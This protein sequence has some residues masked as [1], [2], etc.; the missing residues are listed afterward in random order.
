MSYTLTA[1]FIEIDNKFKFHRYFWEG[2]DAFYYGESSS[3][4]IHEK[5]TGYKLEKHQIDNFDFTNENAYY[6]VA[7]H[8][9]VI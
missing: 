8:Y 9:E 5:I 3:I 6:K 1:L 4:L 2:I 7:N